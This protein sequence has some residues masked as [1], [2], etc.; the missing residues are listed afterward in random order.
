MYCNY[1]L[2]LLILLWI[3]LL[4]ADKLPSFDL[5]T[6]IEVTQYDKKA[7]VKTPSTKSLSLAHKN[8]KTRKIPLINSQNTALLQKVKANYYYFHLLFV[9]FHFSN[10]AKYVNEQFNLY[11]LTII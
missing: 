8:I 3:S 4:S 11:F 1:F 9:F 10:I 7:T 5:K 6:N 2:C